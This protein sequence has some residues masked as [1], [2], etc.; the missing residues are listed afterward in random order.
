MTNHV[1]VWLDRRWRKKVHYPNKNERFIPTSLLDTAQ[2]IK[3]LVKMLTAFLILTP[4]IFALNIIGLT[5]FGLDKATSFFNSY[6]GVF[7]APA[8]VYFVPNGINIVKSM[9]YG[10]LRPKKAEKL[11]HE[12]DVPSF[13]VTT[14][15]RNPV[16]VEKYQS[17]VEVLQKHKTGK[18]DDGTDP[19]LV[20]AFHERELTPNDVDLFLKDKLDPNQI[21]PITDC[22]LTPHHWKE[23][24]N[25]SQIVITENEQQIVRTLIEFYVWLK[26]VGARNP[27]N[28]HEEPT[29]ETILEITRKYAYHGYTKSLRGLL[30][31]NTSCFNSP[32]DLKV[33]NSECSVCGGTPKIGH[34]RK[35]VYAQYGPSKTPL[36]VW[37][38]KTGKFA[39]YFIWAHISYKEALTVID[40]NPNLT[41]QQIAILESLKK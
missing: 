37:G 26:R 32:E 18:L 19:R 5:V 20:W 30:A 3:T 29:F 15:L 36:S 11:T 23:L 24:V 9:I 22:G 28:P 21:I 34:Q 2:S 40:T 41:T 25:A 12:L 4:I 7:F 8:M 38:E 17:Y 31:S 33:S 35:W 10:T 13:R 39:P 1:T 16:P 27:Q 6:L 14:I